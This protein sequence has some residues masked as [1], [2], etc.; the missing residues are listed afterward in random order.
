M[1]HSTI[2]PYS[3]NFND[4]A[5]FFEEKH[6][7]RI[8]IVPFGMS[9]SAF[10][11]IKL[12]EFSNTSEKN[13]LHNI[14]DHLHSIEGVDSV[15]LVD[16]CNSPFNAIARVT[17]TSIESLYAIL[18]SGILKSPDVMETTTMIVINK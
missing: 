3:K 8:M 2:I 6:I 15:Y 16:S 11:L 5:M 4:S 17:A 18:I 12:N 14:Q 10:I 7:L 1:V 13:D 9:T